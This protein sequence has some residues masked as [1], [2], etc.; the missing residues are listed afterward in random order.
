MFSEKFIR[1]GSWLVTMVSIWKR[2]ARNF[3]SGMPDELVSAVVG[4]TDA[5]VAAGAFFRSTSARGVKKVLTP[6]W[7]M[8]RNAEGSR[9]A[10]NLAMSISR[11]CRERRFRVLYWRLRISFRVNGGFMMTRS[12]SPVSDPL[13]AAPG[14]ARSASSSPVVGSGEKRL[15]ISRLSLAAAR[16]SSEPAMVPPLGCGPCCMVNRFMRL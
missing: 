13:G 3:R 12:N 14:S 5:N 16:N 9:F 4:T 7:S 15:A 2:S 6:V 8:A 11:S 1:F 10:R